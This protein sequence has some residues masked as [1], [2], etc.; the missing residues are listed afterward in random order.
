MGKAI[1]CPRCNHEFEESNKPIED[2]PQCEASFENELYY[3]RAR[4]ENL[5]IFTKEA[6]KT[7]KEALGNKRLF[8]E[9][10]EKAVETF[11]EKAGKA[12]IENIFIKKR[13]RA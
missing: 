3:E 2:C 1:T 11:G 4:Q 6:S 9:L 8:E 5:E 12:F 13:N 7:I 10:E